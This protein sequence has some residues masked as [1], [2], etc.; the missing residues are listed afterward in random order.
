[1]YEILLIIVILIAR[2][3]QH[4]MKIKANTGRI[5]VKPHIIKKVILISIMIRTV[6]LSNRYAA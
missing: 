6:I 3:E 5:N 4:Y 2:V 1:M